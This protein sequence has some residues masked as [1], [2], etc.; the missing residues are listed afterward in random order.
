MHVKHRELK[1]RLKKNSK[2][3][4]PISN[5][6]IY[7]ERERKRKIERQPIKTFTVNNEQSVTK[8]KPVS[9]NLEYKIN[10]FGFSV[11]QFT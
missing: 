8:K 2:G 9:H 7:R 4:Y 5:V 11:K 3:I 1:Y 10:L 6:Y